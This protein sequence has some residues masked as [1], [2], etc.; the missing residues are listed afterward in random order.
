MLLLLVLYGGYRAYAAATAP[1]TAPRYMTTT[2]ATG[3]VV[4]TMTETGQVSATQQL[5]LNPKASGQVVGVYVTPGQ[6]VYAGQVIAQLDATDAQRSLQTARLQL[7][8]QQLTY[9]EDTATSTLSLNLLTAQNGVTNAR[10]SLQKTHDASYATLSGIYSDLSKITNDL[11]AVL[12]KST[13]SGRLTQQNIDALSDTVSSYDDQIGIYKASAQDS[14]TAAVAAYNTALAAYKQTGLTLTDDQLM[15]LADQT[16]TATQAVAQAVKDTSDFLDRVSNDYTTY[17]LNAQASLTSLQSTANADT[18]TVNADLGN[19]LTAKSD[20]VS[21][22]QSLASAENTLM[23][24][25]GGANALTVQQ[26]SLAL[27]QAQDAVTNAEETLANYSVTA[28]FS[29]TIASVNVKKYDQA[30][31]GTDV[32]DIVTDQMTVDISVNEVD[33]SNLKVG[34]KAT[35]TFDALPDVTVAGTVSQ[36]NTIGTVSS[37]V[38]TY[39]AVVTFD[40]PNPKVLPGM[41]ATVN[42]ITGTETGLVVPSSAVKTVGTTSMAQVFDPPLSES[43]GAT[44]VQSSVPPKSVPVTVGLT[45]GTNTIIESG[46]GAGAQVVTETTNGS[47]A[48]KASGSLFAPAGS[49]ANGGAN[50]RTGGGFMLRGG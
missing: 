3:T 38:V 49:R 46:L 42:V 28:P 7:Q 5:A 1:S 40:A 31:S 22:E 2:V 41:S 23:Q 15:T 12:H 25:Q 8:N 10:T 13:I 47:S 37:G 17:N 14:Y 16:Y 35:I 43:A 20:V 30:S 19:A 27:K 45:D 50:V 11:D 29:G 4:A 48:A 9:A 39:D 34:Q 6:H 24:A 44:G 36:M 21:A 33:A 18:T 26:A 32:A